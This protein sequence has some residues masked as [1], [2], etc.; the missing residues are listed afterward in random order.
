MEAVGGGCGR[1]DF[2]R[3]AKP[4]QEEDLRLLARSC[5]VVF[6]GETFKEMTD[7]DRLCVG[8]FEEEPGGAVCPVCGYDETADRVPLFLPL[9][10]VLQETYLVGR[11]LGRPG[12]F[13][14]TYLAFDL[15][16]K[17]RV[18]IK[19]YLPLQLAARD[20]DRL[21]VRAHST[22]GEG[23]FR[24]GLS[25]FNQEAQ[26]L[27]RL[28][29]PNIV[30]VRTF[31][32]ANGTAYLVM[33]Y[34]EGE[35]LEAYLERQDGRI[36]EDDALQLMEPIFDALSEE[37]HPQRYLHRDISPQNIYLATLG[38][39]VQP[40][41]IDFGAARQKLG[42]RSQSLSVV[43][44]PGYAPIEQYYSKGRQGPWTDVYACAATLYRAV[45]G[46][47]PPPAVDRTTE[48]LLE[49]PDHLA[50]GLSKEF[51]EALMWGLEM[52]DERR[53]QSVEEFRGRLLPAPSPTPL[54]YPVPTP[55]P[56]PAPQAGIPLLRGVSG[57]LA[58]QEI[59][60][61]ETLIIGREATMSNLV[62]QRT[63]LSRQHCAI[64][65]DDVLGVFQ[66]ED[67]ESSNGTFVE[68]WNELRPLE[69]GRPVTLRPGGRFH[70]VDQDERFEVVLTA[71]GTDEASSELASE[72]LR[73]ATAEEALRAELPGEEYRQP[74][75]DEP[76]SLSDAMPQARSKLGWVLLFLLL[77]GAVATAVVVF[78]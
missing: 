77:V 76:V 78:L 4:H 48:D 9:R 28:R 1:L 16:L 19:E 74:E 33:D 73:S 39:E 15:N 7:S 57:E 71:P 18:A 52:G 35:T 65:Y 29:H 50:P 47:A 3:I 69:P 25:E 27:A 10:T 2:G 75:P 22:K 23:F 13:G 37:V 38:G 17:D 6:E 14:I 67:L 55:P 12:G 8:C 49:P 59:P 58:G 43:L 5:G 31:L 53:P 21:S 26:T 36:P 20:M 62:L 45:T 54:P 70:L 44:K 11:E 41:L 32:Q 40:L 51:C 68:L 34:Y 61:V 46:A 64:R 66:L 42:D 72:D 63:D 60:L 56:P 24:F 30:R